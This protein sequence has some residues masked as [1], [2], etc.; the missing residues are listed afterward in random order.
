MRDTLLKEKGYFIAACLLFNNILLLGS[1]PFQ[2]EF[3]LE[4]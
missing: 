1:I 3:A 4:K 2:I